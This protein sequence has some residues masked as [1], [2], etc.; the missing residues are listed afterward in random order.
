MCLNRSQYTSYG[1]PPN[2]A[3]YWNPGDE[4]LVIYD[5]K[6]SGGRGKTWSTLNHE[7]FHQYIHYFY[8]NLA[9]H[10]WYNEGTGDFYAG[11]KLNGRGK[12][13]L[14]RFDWRVRLIQQNLRDSKYAPLKELVNWEQGEYYGTNEYGLDQGDNYAQGWS[15]IYFLR[16]GKK[17]KARGWDPVWDLI[18]DTYLDSLAATG[19][20]DRSVEKAFAGVDWA[21]MEEA[22]KAYTLQ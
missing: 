14:E 15:F 16:T 9:P 17:G 3:G 8:G 6:E 2:S 1:G 13:D 19:D 22:W 20:L 4:E 10:S 7:A 5:D 11:Y 21:A 18:L 12:F